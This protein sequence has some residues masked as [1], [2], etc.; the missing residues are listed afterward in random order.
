M[1]VWQLDSYRD[2]HTIRC[3]LL[4]SAGYWSVLDNDLLHPAFAARPLQHDEAHEE[5]AKWIG[6]V[7]QAANAFCISCCRKGVKVSEAAMRMGVLQQLIRWR[8]NTSG[9][10]RRVACTRTS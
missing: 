5:E 4:V 2:G 3:R 1:P 6:G 10:Q 7:L 8:K 9:A